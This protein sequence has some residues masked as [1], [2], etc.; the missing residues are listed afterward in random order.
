M[1]AI[2]VLR[3][4]LILVY[5]L[6]LFTPV[7]VAAKKAWV[8]VGNVRDTKAGG[9]SGAGYIRDC[10][11]GAAAWAE[12]KFLRDSLTVCRNDSA[13]VKDFC[14][15]IEDTATCA[16]WVGGHAA[17]RI[18]GLHMVD[19]FVFPNSLGSTNLPK[20]LKT[21]PHI[22]RVTFH[23]CGQNLDEWKKMFPEASFEAWDSLVPAP[24]IYWW[25][26]FSPL[27]QD[28]F[29]LHPRLIPDESLDDG[30]PIQTCQIA[31]PARTA[32]GF[33]LSGL[34]ADQMEGSSIEVAVYD[35]ESRL[36]LFSS[37]VEGGHISNAA[38][39]IQSNPTVDTRVMIH[40]RAMRGLVVDPDTWQTWLDD[41]NI[42][43]TSNLLTVPVEDVAAAVGKMLWAA[44]SASAG[45][46][47]S[48]RPGDISTIAGN[49]RQDFVGDGPALEAGFWVPTGLAIDDDGNIYIADSANNRIRK[50]DP[51]GEI[52]TVAGSDT[53]G[54]GSDGAAA[55]E[56]GLSGPE[57]V[58]VGPDGS[59]YIADTGHHTVRR[60]DPDGTIWQFAG[61]GTVGDSGDGAA[62]TLAQL[63]FPTGVSVD[64]DG[65][66]YVAD[67][68]NHRIRRIDVNGII[69]TFA[70]DGT[71]SEQVANMY[72]GDGGPAIWARLN[73]PNDVFAD[74]LGNVFISDTRNHR[75]RRVDVNGTITTVAGDGFMDPIGG[76]RFQGD[77]GP[78]TLASMGL[79]LGLFVDQTGSLYI[80]DAVYQRIRKVD[81]CG[82]ITTVIGSGITDISN[83]ALSAGYA[84]DGGPAT[85]AMINQP[86]GVVVDRSL[87]IYI[88]DSGNGRIRKVE[89]PAPAPVPTTATPPQPGTIVTLAGDGTSGQTV[90]G[91]TATSTPF[92]S[93]DDIF[94]EDERSGQTSTRSR[95]VSI[96]VADK[97]NHRVVK[98]DT[99]GVIKS[100]AGGGNPVAPD[101]GDGRNATDARLIDPSDIALDAQGN[102][103]IADSGQE[104]IR[105]V[106]PAGVISTVAGRGSPGFGG[107]CGPATD[108]NLSLPLGVFYDRRTSKL[109]IAD[110][111][112]HRVRMVDSTGAISTVAGNGE[113]DSS[114]FGS[115]SGDGGPARLAGLNL[116]TSVHVDN[117][118]YVYIAD[119]FNNRV[120]RVDPFGIIT[121]I[122]G[123]GGA[124]FSAIGGLSGDGGPAT[125]ALL[126]GPEDVS[127]DA[128]GNVYIA[129]TGNN[130]IR[131]VDALGTIQTFAG[132]GSFETGASF[133]GDGGISTLAMLGTPAGVAF[134]PDGNVY[135]ADSG[136]LRI[137][138]IQ[139]TL[140]PTSRPPLPDPTAEILHDRLLASVDASWIFEDVVK[141]DVDTA[142]ALSQALGP[143]LVQALA[144]PRDSSEVQR[145]L[146][147]AI[148]DL[149]A[150]GQI[151]PAPLGIPFIDWFVRLSSIQNAIFLSQ[152]LPSDPIDPV[153]QSIGETVETEV[154]GLRSIIAGADSVLIALS[155]LVGET[156]PS[157]ISFDAVL[158]AIEAADLSP[159]VSF[160]I[161]FTTLERD[162]RLARDASEG[163]PVDHITV[164]L[165]PSPGDQVV[166]QWA[167]EQGDTI[168][169]EIL[170]WLPVPLTG[171][172]QIHLDL[173]GLSLIEATADSVVTGAD[174]ALTLVQDVD[175]LST[176]PSGG[177][178][179]ALMTF[180]VSANVSPFLA[181]DSVTDAGGD[182][183]DLGA[184]SLVLIE[185]DRIV[186]DFDGSGIVDF[187]DFLLFAPAFGT[188]EGET[189]YD[190]RFNLDAANGI[191]F[192]D[193]LLFAAAFGLSSITSP[194]EKE[195]FTEL[196]AAINSMCVR[197]E[198]LG[199]DPDQGGMT[200]LYVAWLYSLTKVGPVLNCDFAKWYYGLKLIEDAI[201]NTRVAIFFKMGENDV[202]KRLDTVDF[203]LSLLR[204]DCVSGGSPTALQVVKLLREMESI[205]SELKA[206]VVE[207]GVEG[208]GI[209][210]GLNRI[211]SK[212]ET[213]INLLHPIK[214]VMFRSL[215]ECFCQLSG[216]LY[217]L[218]ES[219]RIED[220]AAKRR[221]VRE[222][223][224]T[225]NLKKERMGEL[226]LE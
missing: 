200:T 209:D 184:G 213:L 144:N 221:R 193:F 41:G 155:A 18:A 21:Y 54:I 45:F 132:A 164:D 142:Y 176:A 68:D 94:V 67:S 192:P 224:G 91:V 88:T 187:G 77:G 75:V 108:A 197:I 154:D 44:S 198:E 147:Q 119:T 28:L 220:K 105:K 11:V 47:G 186:S 157:Q 74:D 25:E 102:L 181:I 69:S 156:N 83:G 199:D 138:S 113:R 124:G 59:L 104:R 16:L 183:L 150:A 20:N 49:G 179:I 191:G 31:P 222:L 52:T 169:V 185:V 131:V 225:F 65:N 159:F 135:V 134:G 82:T 80:I 37:V 35:E 100:I 6:T 125:E 207:S 177:I 29:S 195:D 178:R 215:Y 51:F 120:R 172:I 39:T 86:K 170:L 205:V 23:A 30:E 78:A 57:D 204:R 145:I 3:L 92:G 87:A 85:D 61:T 223:A 216:T 202:T 99:N 196:V 14:T 38:A 42:S 210:L 171:E 7:S 8:L 66:V 27:T 112:N 167:A 17:K 89:G 55:T 110:T 19:T 163:L 175:V 48:V 226:L 71:E 12:I 146:D 153:V 219:V 206:K 188:E 95:K 141:S 5:P 79:P 211:K 182:S 9:S 201:I 128:F 109:Y 101:V 34:I 137:R 13:T 50:L 62:A 117:L 140:T 4:L 60:L 96:Y 76:A 10:T 217:D 203:Y 97:M 90:S 111:G 107:D 208:A 53:L 64:R 139:T 152:T 174:S 190:V 121:T 81:G 115:F 165:D 180:R 84:G 43:V 160:Y 162:L 127:V 148:I 158:D 122:A 73:F 149:Y 173:G 106:T 32:E 46:A 24:L 26:C 126:R 133:S 214:G 143:D 161:A 58:A 212:K 93:I 40:D 129:D 194:V 33:R 56:V 15:A 218:T 103:Y 114:G 22:K 166:R 118:G 72:A 136:N 63:H 168:Q 98:I 36:T 116:P 123:S 2:H 189:G 130:R 1:T 151:R 70:G